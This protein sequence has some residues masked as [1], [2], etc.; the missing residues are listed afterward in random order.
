MTF[1]TCLTVWHEFFFGYH[2][3]RGTDLEA[4]SSMNSLAPRI[5]ML[6]AC[7]AK[8]P[9]GGWESH[10]NSHHQ[11]DSNW[12]ETMETCPKSLK[13]KRFD[14]LLHW[15]IIEIFETEPYLQCNPWWRR[16]RCLQRVRSPPPL[17]CPC[18]WDQ[19]LHHLHPLPWW[20][21]PAN[22]DTRQRWRCS[23]GSP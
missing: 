14:I 11:N 4:S 3:L 21:A 23:H 12:Q 13:G 5:K 18:N 16:S 7:T 19:R 22:D 8:R 2:V 20:G 6:H 17:L 9:V 1:A 15:K 10:G